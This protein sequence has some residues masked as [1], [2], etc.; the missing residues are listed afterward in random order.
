MCIRGLLDPKR[1]ADSPSPD[2]HSRDYREHDLNPIW[3]TRKSRH[4][5][6]KEVA[7]GHTGR[8]QRG[9]DSPPGGLTAAL[10]LGGS[11]PQILHP[12]YFRN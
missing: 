2:P 1:F 6:V 8:K 7:Q 5:Q 4:R 9:Q 12:V 10:P 3:Q 11:V